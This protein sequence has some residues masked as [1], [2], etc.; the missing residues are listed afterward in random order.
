MIPF[1]LT[2]SVPRALNATFQLSSLRVALISQ[3]FHSEADK[4]TR[5]LVAYMTS[6]GNTKKVA[7]AIYGEISAEKEIKPI[8][9]VQS[10]G[11]YDLAFLGFPTHGYGPD[12][13]TR[14]MIARH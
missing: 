3:L 2:A 7:E 6:T 12:K 1:I 14:E 5:V 13:K 11:G 10:L 9:E 4:M 8:Q